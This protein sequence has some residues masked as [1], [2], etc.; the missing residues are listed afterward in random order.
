MKTDQAIATTMGLL[1]LLLI[2]QKE[3]N[4]SLKQFSKTNSSAVDVI[5]CLCILLCV[6]LSCY[7]M[8]VVMCEEKN[9]PPTSKSQCFFYKINYLQMKGYF[10][11]LLILSLCVCVTY[12]CYKMGPGSPR[13]S[14][15]KEVP[16]ILLPISKAA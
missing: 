1:F 7:V 13:A 5:Y 16:G 15:K 14:L 12:F 8:Y 4:L 9:H 3:L 10:L 6:L 11:A 2:L